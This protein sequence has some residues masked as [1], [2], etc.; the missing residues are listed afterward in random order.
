MNTT[1][2]LKLDEPLCFALYAVTNQIVRAYRSPLAAI[3]LTYSQY[4]AMWV[5]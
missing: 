1:S 2:A 4:L 3:G 5:R